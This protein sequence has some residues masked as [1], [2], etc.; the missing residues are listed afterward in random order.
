[1]IPPNHYRRRWQFSL[2]LLAL[3]AS[4][5]IHAQDKAQTPAAP[6]TK[7]AEKIVRVTGEHPATK[8]ALICLVDVTAAPEL[9]KW[10]TDAAN[11]A[12]KHYPTI[13]KTLVTE[14]YKPTREFRLLFKDMP[15]VAH[16]SG[17]VIT[18]SINYVK[19]NPDDWGMVAHELTHVIQ[20]Y[21]R[22]E[23]WLTE[24]IADY[25]RYY[26][27]EPGSRRARF[28]INRTSYKNAYQPAAGFLD[29]LERTK[30]GTVSK[31]N[32]ALRAGKYKPELFVEIAGGT[33]DELWEK[34]KESKK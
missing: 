25:V 24:G 6:A 19:K 32:A 9:E 17:N 22:G 26:V 11:Y 30:P 10:G 12:I 28:D 2:I 21:R 15:G 4:P 23:G 16:A 34:F 8:E 18:I 5:I 13:E 7:P 20:R 29:Y 3:I 14:G 33:P 31:L 1:M 27:I